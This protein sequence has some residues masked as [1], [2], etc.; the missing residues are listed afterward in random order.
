MFLGS[1]SVS[2]TFKPTGLEKRGIRGQVEFLIYNQCFYSFNIILC[3]LFLEHK[4]LELKCYVP[5]LS[6][7]FLEL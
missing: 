1:D 4:S 5:I 3:N 7:F 6:Q 2:G